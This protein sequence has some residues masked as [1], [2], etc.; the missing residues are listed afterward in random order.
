VTGKIKHR[1]ATPSIAS[2]PLQ[3]S[4][5]SKT[6]LKSDHFNGGGSKRNGQRKVIRAPERRS[7]DRFATTTAD[8]DEYRHSIGTVSDGVHKFTEVGIL[9]VRVG[10]DRSPP[11]EV[12]KACQLF[13][14]S[15]IEMRLLTL[16]GF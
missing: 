4:L 7:A 15:I 14:V 13:R 16:E 11:N 5:M 12:D 3:S 8:G 1:N 9:L 2:L 6:Y 10:I